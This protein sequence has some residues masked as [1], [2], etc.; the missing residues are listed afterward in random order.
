MSTHFGVNSSATSTR[1]KMF[2]F[3]DGEIGVKFEVD[4]E[5]KVKQ[6]IIGEF[7][8]KPVEIW[9]IA[10]YGRLLIEIAAYISVIEDY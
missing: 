3:R 10:D 5:G 7:H 9:Q 8:D 2:P 4:K 1:F 6:V